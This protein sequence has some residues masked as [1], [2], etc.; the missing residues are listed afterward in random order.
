MEPVGEQGPD[1]AVRIVGQS[2]QSLGMPGWCGHRDDRGE[3]AD[4]R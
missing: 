2:P 3:L 4:D 1:L